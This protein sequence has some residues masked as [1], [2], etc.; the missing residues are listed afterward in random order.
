[1]N[2]ST[3]QKALNENISTAPGQDATQ[4]MLWN[5]SKALLEMAETLRDL[6]IG[7]ERSKQ[8]RGGPIV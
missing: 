5:I 4:R 6:Q 1:M 7:L 2:F 8:D 3:I